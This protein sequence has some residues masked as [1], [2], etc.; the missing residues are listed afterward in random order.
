MS[1][2]TV[3]NGIHGKDIIMG[4]IIVTTLPPIFQVRSEED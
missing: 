3:G 4:R 1:V 2:G